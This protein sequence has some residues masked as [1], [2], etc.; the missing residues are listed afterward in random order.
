[1]PALQR[2][3]VWDMGQIERLFDSLMR[4]YPIGSFLFWYVEK[5]RS[6]D[7]QFYDFIRNYHERY[8]KHIE[9]IDISGEDDI[10][11]ILDGQ[12]RLTALYIGLKGTYAKK[13]PYKYYTND[14]AYPERKLYL[15]LFK[16]SDK[17]DMEY[18]FRFLTNKEFEN[19]DDDTH[20]FKVGDVLDFD[21]PAKVIKYLIKK[22]LTQE[23]PE[24]ANFANE[25]LFDLYETLKN[26]RIINYYLEKS[27]E[28]DKVLNIF[29]RINSGGT[30]LSYSDLLLSI[31]TTQWK[32]MDAREEITSFVD[33]INNIGDGFNFNNDFVLKSS[34]ILSDFK[35]IAFRVD[36]F[37]KENMLKI[38]DNW[39]L[40]KKSIKNSVELVSSLGFNS[41]LLVANN[42]VIPIAYN[43]M[44]IGNPKS[45]NSLKYREDRKKIHKWLNICLIKRTFGGQ[46]DRVLRNMRKVIKE[47]HTSFPLEEISN[48]LKRTNKSLVFDEDEITN[49]FYNQYG[50]TYT[51]STLALLYP[52]LDFNNLFH[53]D[54]I[55]PK[56]FFNKRN[57]ES[58]NI[59]NAE[60]YMDHFNDIENL[61][62][63]EGPVNIEKSNMAFECWLDKYYNEEEKKGFMKKHY[64]PD[65]N[66]DFNNF[67]EFVNERRELM[68]EEFES[69]LKI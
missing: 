31:A 6:K 59:E 36:N 25:T 32:K 41:R 58:E 4:D 54:H 47:N 29:I 52:T 69:V 24:K 3:L 67:E 33:E 62:L 5:E 37:K 61:Q 56:S 15:N 19:S 57:L 53:L 26:K 55:H 9:K 43:L 50:G 39:E 44:K 2:D 48:A 27:E 20:W 8:R 38:E 51:F 16:K 23:D 11:A 40:I 68:R 10:T 13:L 14:K 22:G 45:Y 63:L 28:L 30:P 21:K 1:M 46:S 60:F 65:V 17:M 7:F 64:I 49:L 18:D 42:A 34:L 66:L 12:Q 35:N